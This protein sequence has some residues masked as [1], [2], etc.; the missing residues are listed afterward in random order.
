MGNTH[1]EAIATSSNAKYPDVKKNSE[2]ITRIIAGIESKTPVFTTID[3]IEFG[4]NVR[5]NVDSNTLEFKQLM[6]SIEE[7]GLLQN[8]VVEFHQIDHEKYRFVLVSGFRRL[9]AMK[10]ISYS[11]PIPVLPILPTFG[12]R[13]Q[14]LSE[15]IHRS[16][17]HF[18]EEAETFLELKEKEGRS[19]DYIGNLFERTEAS[20]GEYI[21]L[22]EI[23]PEK[24]KEL[25]MSNKD[26][27]GVTYMIHTFVRGKEKSP[28][29]IIS[30]LKRRLKSLQKR[31]E[32]NESDI[33]ERTSK[34]KNNRH[35]KINKYCK[36]KGYT[37]PTASKIVEA[38][39]DFG[40]I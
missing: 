26:A 10:K 14:A 3:K 8:L 17:L 23:L 22:A 30:M 21:K 16:S 35:E 33:K 25:V 1:D 29:T 24:A 4:P 15:N 39:R 11:K 6:D 32:E 31:S 18:I 28:G 9:T 13:G 7:F 5:R 34:T 27:F 20:V 12:T 2:G 19:E 40:Y 37:A 36:E 38:F